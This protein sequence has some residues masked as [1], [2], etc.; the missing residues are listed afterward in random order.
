MALVG[1]GRGL[2]FCSGMELQANYPCSGEYPILMQATLNSVRNKTQQKIHNKTRQDK[3]EIP[4]LP[5]DR[6]SLCSPGYCV[7]H[8]VGLASL[9]PPASAT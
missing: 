1:G 9:D 8:Y 6:V 4:P 7:T 3:K 5:Q 2:I